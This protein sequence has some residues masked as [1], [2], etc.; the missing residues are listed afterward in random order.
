MPLQP[1]IALQVQGLQL[2]DPLAQ[3]GRVAQIQNALQEQR[4]GEMKIQNAMREQRREQDYETVLSG[5]KPGMSLEERVA[6]LQQRGLGA[7]GAQ[8]AE[9]QLKL[10]KANRE[11]EAARIKAQTDRIGLMGQLLSS[12]SDQS[13]LDAVRPQIARIPG[14]TEDDLRM[15]Q[16]Y[17]D[18]S[19]IKRLANASMTAYQRGSLANAQMT[20]EAGKERARAATSQAATA[21]AKL[22]F[23]RQRAE[24]AM[25]S[26]RAAADKQTTERKTELQRLQE[27]RDS[28]PVGSVQRAEV[29]NVIDARGR[30]AAPTLTD[31]VDP[32]D[33]TRMLKVDARLYTGGGFTAPGVV[34]IAGKEP[35]AG[36]RATEQATARG[37]FLDILDTLQANFDELNRQR[38]IPSEQRGA[39]SNVLSS[40]EASGPG[41][42]AGRAV[43]ARAQSLRDEIKSSRMA[44]MS[45]LKKLT[46]KSASE[47]N[48]NV[49]LRLNLDAISDPSQSYEAATKILE[50][51]KQFYAQEPA[52]TPSPG[53]RP[54]VTDRRSSSSTTRGTAP[55]EVPA[56]RTVHE[57]EA[58]NLP[59]GTRITVGG[60]PAE[61]N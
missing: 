61:V 21:A 33:P 9:T 59:K 20:A 53:G 6:A 37:Q 17:G 38:A 45:A 25:I 31:I 29:D 14:V 46:G 11:A 43:G 49:E 30:P 16:T 34:G 2:P 41:Q 5:F 15:L 12:V 7:K 55:S 19:T 3:S 13:T 24:A 32:D 50:N 40:I 27:L 39:V 18:G 48:S 10:D 57:A 22:P 51:L 28:L 36:K 4:M 54:G 26:A 60:R 47:L 44:L 8:Y 35:S 52:P 56:F 1:N 23:E 42:V 58:A